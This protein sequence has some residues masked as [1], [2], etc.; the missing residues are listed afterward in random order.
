[1]KPKFAVFN[2]IG[3]M[4]GTVSEQHQRRNSHG[5]RLGSRTARCAVTD[6]A[7]ARQFAA[8]Q[9]ER[10]VNR[11]GLHAGFRVRLLAFAR[12]A[13]V[14][15]LIVHHTSSL[16]LFSSQRAAVRTRTGH[17]RSER[18]FSRIIPSA[19]RSLARPLQRAGPSARPRCRLVR[20][21]QAD[22]HLP[23]TRAPG[24]AHSK[25]G[26]RTWNRPATGF[27]EHSVFVP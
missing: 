13:R 8:S 19:R 4:A 24:S 20:T 25:S 9:R 7:L 17:L 5:L 27:R 3:S 14:I 6:A 18:H 12:T 11:L 15:F 23:S 1:M 2:A 16:S 26:S 10:F 22:L 21:H